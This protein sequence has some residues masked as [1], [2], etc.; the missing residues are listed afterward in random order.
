MDL[1]RAWRAQQKKKA[2]KNQFELSNKLTI[3]KDNFRKNENK[4]QTEEETL[5]KPY[6]INRC[7]RIR[8]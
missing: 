4:D 6:K 7:P 2:Y 5:R 3:I 8:I 1:G